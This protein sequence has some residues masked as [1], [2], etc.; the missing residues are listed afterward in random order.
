MTVLALAALLGG[1]A[2]GPDYVRPAMDLPQAY[3]EQGPES[4]R[5]APGR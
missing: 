1:C 5:P 3:K 2:V 4:G